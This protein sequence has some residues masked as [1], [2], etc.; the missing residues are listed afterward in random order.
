MAA[1]VGTVLIDIKADTA[2][3]VSGMNRAENAVKKSVDRMKRTIYALVGAYVSLQGA[4]KIGEFAKDATLVAAEFERLHAVMRTLTGSSTEGRKAMN[5]ITQFTKTTPYQLEQ[6]ANAFIKLKAYGIDATKELKTLGD[7]AAAMGKPLDQ[8][9]EALADAMT[10]EFERL[11]EFGIKAHQQGEKV[12]FSWRDASGKAKYIVVQNNSEIIE[13]TLRAIWNSKYAGAMEQYAQTWNGMLSNLRDNYTIFKKSIMDGGLFNY[14]KS[15]LKVI[16]ERSKTVFSTSAEYVKSWVN[17]GIRGI[18]KFIESLGFLYDSFT[19]IRVVTNSL[20]L[21]FAYLVKGI[22]TAFLW[23]RK[24]FNWVFEKLNAFIDFYNSLPKWLVGEHS[25]IGHIQLYDEE[26][27]KRSIAAIDAYIAHTKEE[28]K[29][30]AFGLEDGRKYAKGFVADVQKEFAKLK[31]TIDDGKNNP[32]TSVKGAVDGVFKSFKTGGAKAKKSVK[33]VAHYTETIFDRAT[34]NI[35]KSFDDNFFSAI[36]GKF[37]DFK[38]FL[39]SLFR[40]ILNSII[41]PFARYLSSSL[42]GAL[43]GVF[44]VPMAGGVSIAQS[45]AQAGFKA[46]GEG[47]FKN[48]V[49]QQ[50]K[51]AGGQVQA[52]DASGNP[53]SLSSVAGLPSAIKSAGAVLSNPSGTVANLIYAPSQ[54]F[55]AIAGQAYNI[56]VVGQYVGD[57]FSGGAAL[58]SGGNPAGMGLSA[59]LGGAAI[60]ALGGY[61]LG[62]LGDMLFGADTK[63]GLYGAIGGAVGSLAGPLGALI[64]SVLGSA[65][66]GLFGKWKTQETGKWIH[67][68]L[69]STNIDP[70]IITDYAYKKKK[71]W[72]H[73]KK[74]WEK[75][76]ISEDELLSLKQTMLSYDQLLQGFGSKLSMTLEK[77]KLQI[78]KKSNEFDEYISKEFLQN[79]LGDDKLLQPLK[80]VFEGKYKDFGGET[81]LFVKRFYERRL[82]WI[83]KAIENA[84]TEAEKERLIEAKQE[85]TRLNEIYNAWKAYAEEQ[86]KSVSEAMAQAFA[87]VLTNKDEHAVWLAEF[88]GKHTEALRLKK[89]QAERD[90]QRIRELTG[91]TELDYKNFNKYYEE[92]VKAHPT[93]EQLEIWDQAKQVVE[94]AAEAQIEYSEAV[95]QYNESVKN[96]IDNVEGYSFYNTDSTEALYKKI[97][98]L[99]NELGISGVTVENF[100]QKIGKLDITSAE[101]AQSVEELGNTLIQ[102]SQQIAQDRQNYWLAREESDVAFEALKE[103]VLQQQQDFSEQLIEDTN[104]T[105]D[106]IIK[107]TEEYVSSLQNASDTLGGLIDKLTEDLV[108]YQYTEGLF[109][110]TLDKAKEELFNKDYENYA[111]TVQDLSNYIGFLDQKQYAS[112]ADMRYEKALI[113]NELKTLKSPTDIMIE[114]LQQIST[115][116]QATAG[117]ASLSAGSLGSVQENIYKLVNEQLGGRNFEEIVANGIVQ[118]IKTDNLA[119]VLGQSGQSLVTQLQNMNAKWDKFPIANGKMM[120]VADFDEDGVNDIAF[121]IDA[122]GKITS[123]ETQTANTYKAIE[124]SFGDVSLK[125]VFNKETLQALAGENWAIAIGDSF[126]LIK[127]TINS[128]NGTILSMGNKFVVDI[129]Q[130]G[131]WDFVLVGDGTG[132]LQAIQQNTG[133]TAAQ[134]AAYIAKVASQAGVSLNTSTASQIASSSTTA[135]AAA[136]FYSAVSEYKKLASEQKIHD[137]NWWKA[138]Y[139]KAKQIENNAKQLAQSGYNITSGLVGDQYDTIADVANSNI[140]QQIKDLAQKYGVQLRGFMSG[141]Y[142]G[143]IPP[144]VIA[145]VVHGQEFVVNAPTTRR[146]GLNKDNGGIFVEILKELKEVKRENAELRAVVAR[147][148]PNV[149]RNTKKDAQARIAG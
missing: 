55:G 123:I 68:T 5:W 135:S 142:T 124:K 14:F 106:T 80:E 58:L 133:S 125:E 99:E 40:D 15:I 16:L 147:H 143:D 8:A 145:G 71:S 89:E 126:N 98:D 105:Y 116:T 52:F 113:L 128:L 20:K 103:K 10:G 33:E 54:A 70:E 65:I 110:K 112:A 101:A 42:S 37:H 45:L 146:L 53:I 28:I 129:D 130:N 141:G 118:G 83:D 23:A 94:H 64:G 76:G 86:K 127:D 139:E 24:S 48:A 109:Y 29:S 74:K 114:Q 63:A 4:M 102:L 19:G 95:K 17:V 36:T 104:K 88:E 43:M 62:K 46:V 108:G 69:T 132:H 122:S 59:Q 26:G 12:A 87:Q 21:G 84:A 57:F 9:V 93:P 137:E 44:G 3:L 72:F 131:V 91:I 73:T 81:L 67:D 25:K 92:A 30:L 35:Y 60:G 78:S 115:N 140:V 18:N 96:T 1:K 79:F 56:P 2:K 75:Y 121:G 41:N 6:V 117:Y 61:L 39:R 149:D 13:S 66:G 49:G 22:S 107:N 51:I 90:L 50:V 34:Q 85:W 119:A 11:K 97:R 27:Y 120:V 31:G 134:I 138:V 136:S 144:S 47:V 111:Q 38:D 77:G 82:G 100:A 32:K 148:L 7:T